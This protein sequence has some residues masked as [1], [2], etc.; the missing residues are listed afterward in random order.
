MK[1]NQLKVGE[2]FVYQNTIYAVAA[3]DKDNIYCQDISDLWIKRVPKT[4]GITVITLTKAEVEKYKKAK[5]ILQEYAIAYYAFDQGVNKEED[6]YKIM[7]D[8]VFDL[9]KI[10]TY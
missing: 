8:I 6:L 9:A 3:K 5:K 1:F 4:K 2:Y 10:K 7:E